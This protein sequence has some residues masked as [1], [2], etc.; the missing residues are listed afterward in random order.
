[1][2]H[3]EEHCFTR[4]NTFNGKKLCIEEMERPIFV[5]KYYAG[6][7][8][9]HMFREVGQKYDKNSDYSNFCSQ[10]VQLKDNKHDKASQSSGNWNIGMPRM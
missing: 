3:V 9:Q 4:R 10:R 2:D 5:N 1:M 7:N 8:P 6:D